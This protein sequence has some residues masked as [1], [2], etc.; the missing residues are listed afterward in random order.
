MMGVKWRRNFYYHWSDFSKN[1]FNVS[2]SGFASYS[3]IWFLYTNLI[4]GYPSTLNLS[5]VPESSSQ[6]ISINF[7]V[8][9]FIC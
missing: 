6:S 9:P 4:V 1:V 2:T 8:V 3:I 7:T 5:A